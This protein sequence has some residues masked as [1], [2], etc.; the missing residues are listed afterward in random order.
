MR[1]GMIG[2]ASLRSLLL[3]FLCVLASWREFLF[4]C[5]SWRE[6]FQSGSILPSGMLSDQLERSS[7]KRFSWFDAMPRRSAGAM[8]QHD[9]IETLSGPFSGSHLTDHF[10]Q[11]RDRLDELSD[12][13]FAHRNHQTGRKQRDLCVQPGRAILNFDPGWNAVTG[14]CFFLETT[15]ERSHVDCRAKVVLVYARYVGEPFE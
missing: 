14:G 4:F 2:G 7:G 9:N 11:S 12:S 10:A 8:R 1:A 15:T 6:L 13:Q 5:A 3:F